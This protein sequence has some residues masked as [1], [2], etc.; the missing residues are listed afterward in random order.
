MGFI[1]IVFLAIIQGLTEF[2]PVSSSAHLVILPQIF[3]SVSQSIGIDIAVH[4]GSLLAVIHI[5]WN[6][7][8]RLFSGMFDVILL[9]KHDIRS[10]IFLLTSVATI[11]IVVIT[12][13][14]FAF[15]LTYLLRNIYVIS[16]A[17]IFF[18]FHFFWLIRI[19]QK[20]GKLR[21]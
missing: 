1:H 6:D 7:L 5:F 15:N 10:N 8:K 21:I 17:S 9:K 19:L 3:Y 2:I 4:M 13:L 20:Q 14:L 16:I 12:I 18:P 11:P